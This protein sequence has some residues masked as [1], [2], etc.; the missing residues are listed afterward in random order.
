MLI[1][2]IMPYFRTKSVQYKKKTVF[3]VYNS[4]ILFIFRFMMIL[5]KEQIFKLNLEKQK[6]TQNWGFLLLNF[7]IQF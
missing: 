2:K 5:H 1:Q 4:I 3:N 7:I 6:N